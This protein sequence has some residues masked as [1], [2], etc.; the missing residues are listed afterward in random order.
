MV[1]RRRAAPLAPRK[2]SKA[3]PGSKRRPRH[4]RRY[5]C[6][7]HPRFHHHLRHRR[8]HRHL[9]LPLAHR[10][11][12]PLSARN[13]LRHTPAKRPTF[14]PVK[15]YKKKYSSIEAIIDRFDSSRRRENKREEGRKERRLSIQSVSKSILLIKRSLTTA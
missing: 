14:P 2:G 8:L 4:L 3:S 9:R 12:L 1:S 15:E 11:A 5:R 13:F 6:F 7:R 10:L